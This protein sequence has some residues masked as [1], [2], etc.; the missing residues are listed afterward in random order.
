MTIAPEIP[1]VGPPALRAL[2]QIGDVARS[3]GQ[4]AE[5]AAYVP[6]GSIAGGP[7]GQIAAS[8][9]TTSEIAAGTIVAANISAESITGDLIAANTITSTNIAAATIVGGNI[10]AN[11]I[12]TSN[13]AAGAIDGMTITGSTFQTAAS[14]PTGGGVIMDDTGIAGYNALGQRKFMLDATTGL[15]SAEGVLIADTNSQLPVN[16]LVGMLPGSANRYSNAAF[17]NGVNT[18]DTTGWSIVG[19][20][21]A[22]GS[23]VPP[24]YGQIE[25]QLTASVAGDIYVTP[26]TVVDPYKRVLPGINYT[27]SHYIYSNTNAR[28]VRINVQ[29]Y[30]SAGTLLSEVVGTSVS[31]PVGQWT[32][33][34]QTQQ[35]PA[36]AA[37]ARG[38]H[39]VLSAAASDVFFTEC[40][41][42]EEGDRVSAWAPRPDE[43]LYQ[44]I[45][46]NHL[47]VTALSAITAN[48]GTVTAGTITGVLIQSNSGTSSTQMDS[49]GFYVTDVGTKRVQ[50]AHNQANYGMQF[51]LTRG[52]VSGYD[53][54]SWVQSI[55]ASPATVMIFGA[56]SSTVSSSRTSGIWS[57]TPWALAQ[58]HTT[59]MMYASSDSGDDAY[60]QIYASVLN[61]AGSNA[62]NRTIV[63]GLGRGSFVQIGSTLGTTP[64]P[65][66]QRMSWPCEAYLSAVNG[67]VPVGWAQGAMDS[68]NYNNDNLLVSNGN[69]YFSA[70][71]TG[72]YLI[73]YTAEWENA[74]GATTDSVIGYCINGQYYVGARNPEHF[75]G[76]YWAASISRILYMS[77]GTWVTP[78]TYTSVGGGFGSLYAGSASSYFGAMRIA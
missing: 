17:Q 44:Q 34:T 41:Q 10:A 63:D 67:T 12:T 8:S 35:A 72:Y 76:T 43:I 25:M 60:N 29:W 37:Y 56:G 51:G 47:N 40:Y 15:L 70:P 6:A 22:G 65:R 38:V 4:I 32:R 48:L 33:V 19:A 26:S 21:A 52:S 46:A 5:K 71:E 61:A 58:P 42:M 69:W 13:L 78:A 50:I 62:Y 54:I 64:N 27:F 39:Y 59:I 20:T 11:T 75:N 1:T 7:T 77:A 30:N 66:A 68:L 74:T 31:A 57:I 23:S 73:W 18:F 3:I 45:N 55:S 28:N 49:T 14:V 24:I 2:Q 16:T 53:H 36:G 9:I